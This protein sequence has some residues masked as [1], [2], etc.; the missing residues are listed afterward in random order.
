MKY[1]MRLVTKY[2]NVDIS[3]KVFVM[4]V[5]ENTM[6]DLVGSQVKGDLTGSQI[7]KYQ[8]IRKLAEGGFAEVYLGEHVFTRYV[9]CTK[10]ESKRINLVQASVQVMKDANAKIVA[11]VNDWEITLAMVK[12]V[13][14]IKELYIPYCI[15]VLQQK[16][17]Q[18]VEPDSINTLH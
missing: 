3:Y 16:L 18:A 4:V 6:A 10:E 5:K 2:N 17:N 1:S 15:D 8:I 13:C 7:E 9:A 11:K 12:R 14:K